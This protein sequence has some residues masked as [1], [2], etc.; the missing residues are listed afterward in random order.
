MNESWSTLPFSN[1]CSMSFRMIFFW[2]FLQFCSPSQ[3]AG[4]LFKSVAYAKSHECRVYESGCVTF[5]V[6]FFFV[7]VCVCSA[8]SW[9]IHFLFILFC[10]FSL[11]Y[12]HHFSRVHERVV[13][14]L[15]FVR[16][17]TCTTWL[18]LH[19]QKK[20]KNDKTA[21]VKKII[22]LET[23]NNESKQRCHVMC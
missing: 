10:S 14:L 11:S 15:L 7:F 12:L 22:M 18:V 23:G 19:E 5:L 3:E 21:T 20:E 9:K 1:L 6:R 16:Y 4:V 8:P 13:V 17:N 2:L